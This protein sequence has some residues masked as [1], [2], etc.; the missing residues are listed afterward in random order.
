[1]LASLCATACVKIPA[2]QGAG[3]DA[4]PE[5]GDGHGDGDGDAN[6]NAAFEQWAYLKGANTTADDRLGT[7]VA[8]SGNG[9]TLAVGVPFE[10]GAGGINSTPDD[11]HL[12]AGA[13][14]VFIATGS[15]WQQQAYI[16]ATGG[17]SGDWFGHAVALSQD[18]NTLAVGAPHRD[19]GGAA[20]AGAVFVF[21]RSGSAWTQQAMVKASNFDA[22]DELGSSV[23]LSNDGNRLVVGAPLEDGSNTGVNQTVNELSTDAG[24]AYIFQRSATTWSPTPAYL[25]A[26]NTA[27]MHRFGTTVAMSGDGATVAVGTISESS[28]QT[29]V[30][31]V[32]GG[33][34]TVLGSGAVY[35]YNYTS[36]WAFTSRIKADPSGLNWNFGAALALSQTG[37]VLAVGMPG[38]STGGGTRTGSVIVYKHLSAWVQA[39]RLAASNAALNDLFGTSVALSRDGTKI[40][41]GATGEDSAAMGIDGDQLSDGSDSSGAAYLFEEDPMMWLQTAYIKASNP[42]V[43]DFFGASVALADVAT[44]F[45][46]GAPG[47]RSA[48]TGVNADP[49]SDDAAN[50]GAA[51]V[52][53]SP[54]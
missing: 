25:K 7:S 31:P 48:G 54:E 13:V 8:I 51:Y 16:K 23:A 34:G 44:T 37:T 53:R 19:P 24:A 27:T 4:G 49:S 46:I 42:G 6:Q 36:S 21:V 5:D 33:G 39:A 32:S 3:G 11:E 15:G 1:M 9:S 29:G 35:L 47:E 12:D 40:L 28:D 14:Y 30:D 22:A 2:F 26:S 20:T 43:G 52:F 45:A 38:D 50:A 41:V 17:A 10:D 18:G